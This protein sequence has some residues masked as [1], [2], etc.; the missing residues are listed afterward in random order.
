M[1]KACPG[2]FNKNASLIY[3]VHRFGDIRDLAFSTPPRSEKEQGL[4]LGGKA[5]TPIHKTIHKHFF[6]FL[7]Q[8]RQ[9]SQAA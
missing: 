6:F 9:L 2:Q 7:N 8:H 4:I 1:H 5:Q 3:L